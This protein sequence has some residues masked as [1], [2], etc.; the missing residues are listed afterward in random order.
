MKLYSLILF[1][2]IVLFTV[3]CSKEKTYP[4]APKRVFMAAKVAQ[5]ATTYTAATAARKI[6]PDAVARVYVNRLSETDVIA[7]FAIT[8][9]AVPGVHFTPPANL[10]V[11]I[12]VG[13]YYGEIN[14]K[15]LND[16]AQTTARTVLFTLVSAT[17]GFEPGLG[18]DYVFKNFTYTINP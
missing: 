13:S 16:P 14:F 9:T 12:P 15:V 7:T 2:T 10:Q 17:A 1:I 11:T 3:S 5:G 4:D 6:V 8:G 18:T